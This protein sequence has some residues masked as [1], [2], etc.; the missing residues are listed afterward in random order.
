M[1]VLA[2]DL[3]SFSHGSIHYPS[4]LHYLTY[5]GTHC[6]EKTGKMAKNNALSGKTQGLWKFCQNTGNLVC[7]SCKFPDSKGK[8]YFYICCENFCFFSVAGK[9]CQVSFVYIIVT[10]HVN[11]HRQNLHSDRANTGNLRM[12]FEWV[13]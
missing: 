5:Q 1:S 6:T 9:V 10:N 4:Y 7:S 3:H 8:R 2:R 12:Q 13:P 11:W